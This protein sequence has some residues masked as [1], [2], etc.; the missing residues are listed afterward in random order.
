MRV[1]VDLKN[2]VI[3]LTSNLA[4]DVITEVSKE[5]NNGYG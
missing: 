4:T 5:D 2:T 1:V 3:F